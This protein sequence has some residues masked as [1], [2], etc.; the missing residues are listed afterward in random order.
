MEA[1]QYGPIVSRREGTMGALILGSLGLLAVSILLAIWRRRGAIPYE[2]PRLTIDALR[3][4]QRSLYDFGIAV[5]PPLPFGDQQAR[6]RH[7]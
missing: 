5:G 6:R 2:D 7:G 4:R 3:E 1:L